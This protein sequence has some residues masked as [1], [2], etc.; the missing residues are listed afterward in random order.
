[1]FAGASK[2]ANYRRSK[3][4]AVPIVAGGHAW[5]SL[6]GSLKSKS[7]LKRTYFLTALAAFP[8]L[9]KSTTEIITNIF[10]TCLSGERGSL[11]KGT[12]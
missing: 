12:N 6:L 8:S 4:R 3:V 1:M 11:I 10:I 7:V 5:A 9:K 2:G